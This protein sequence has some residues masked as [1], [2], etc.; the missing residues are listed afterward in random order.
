MSGAPELAAS[1]MER[2]NARRYLIGLGLGLGLSM[3]GDTAL[4][5]VAGMWVKSLTGSSAL[6]ELTQTCI[7]IP[8]LFGA[9][10]GLVA[11]RVP[12]QRFLIVV[13]LCSSI[14]VA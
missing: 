2:R 1:T 14:A 9:L 10:A 4:S 7:Y 11:D 8:P 5:L 6:A 12:R 13:K 3:I